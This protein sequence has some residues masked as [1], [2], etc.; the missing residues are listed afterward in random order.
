[1][2]GSAMS[3]IVTPDELRELAD[4]FASL[5]RVEPGLVA[6]YLR[7]AANHIERQD[8]ELAELREKLMYMSEEIERNRAA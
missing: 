7:V 5:P 1:M 3:D 8:A 2:E 6:H 4:Q